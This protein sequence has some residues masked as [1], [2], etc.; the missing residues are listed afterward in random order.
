M[1]RA[2][3]RVAGLTGEVHS[4]P[5][6]VHAREN[7]PNPEKPGETAIPRG[8]PFYVLHYLGEG[9]WLSWYKGTLVNVENFSDAGPFPKS[10]W[11][12]K[13]KTGKGL[14][15]WAVSD[16]NFEGQDRLA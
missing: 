11:W 16:G 8:E 10:V 3:E 13:V 12:V 9:Y 6:L 15:A 5:V 2:G 1:V 14:V 7:I 4:V